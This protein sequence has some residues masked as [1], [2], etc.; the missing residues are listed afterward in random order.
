[1]PEHCSGGRI[2]RVEVVIPSPDVDHRGCY[3]IDRDRGHRRAAYYAQRTHRSAVGSR[4]DV[5]WLLPDRAAIC[6]VSGMLVAVKRAPVDDTI[7]HDRLGKNI[8]ACRF[9]GRQGPCCPVLVQAGGRNRGN[10]RLG[11]VIAVAFDV[12]HICRPVT[13][14]SCL[15]SSMDRVIARKGQVHTSQQEGHRQEGRPFARKKVITHCMCVL[16]F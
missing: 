8:P 15:G 16:R 2:E 6:H 13:C 10:Q 11:F 5:G 7:G 3:A 1:M 4:A 12:V 9:L 14:R